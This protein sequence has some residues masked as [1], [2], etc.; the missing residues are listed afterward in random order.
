MLRPHLEHVIRAGAQIADDENLV[1]VGSQAV[2]GSHPDAPPSLLVSVEADLYPREH[3]E[4]AVVIDGAIG[5]GSPFHET[6]GYYAHG[7][8][9]ETVKAPDGWSERLFPLRNANTAGATGW[10]LEIHD[11]VLAKC[12][13]GREKDWKFVEDSI[14]HDLVVVDDLRARVGELPVDR[15]HRELVRQGLEGR[16]VKLSR[17][18]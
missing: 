11:L 10:C 3:P 13:A 18:N 7:V 5:E 4:R 8:G 12:V 15:D 14:R 16:L 6:F 9:P 17:T 2:L 1:I